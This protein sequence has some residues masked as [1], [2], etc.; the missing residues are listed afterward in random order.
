MGF[1]KEVRKKTLPE[2]KKEEAKID[3]VT[4]YIIRG[5]A[6]LLTL[7]FVKLK[8]SATAVTKF[9]LVWVI[10][11]FVFFMME[12]TQYALLGMLS[13]FIWDVLDGIDG[14]IARYTNTCSVNGGLWDATVGWLATFGFFLA[15]GLLAF[16]EDSAVVLDFIPK[17]YYIIF[18]AIAGFALI[19]PRLVMHKKKGMTEDSNIKELKDRKH[20]SI[21]KKIVFNLDSI[22]GLGFVIFILCFFFNLTNLCTIGYLLLNGAIA[23]GMCYKLLK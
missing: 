1:I 14:N 9:S 19:F 6:D 22:N 3:I 8:I 17:Y 11:M 16:R 5:I 2:E 10:L 20:Y 23:L 18:G 12:G 21:L 7:P 15:M 13:F 4:Y